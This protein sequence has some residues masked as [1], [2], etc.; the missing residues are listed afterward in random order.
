MIGESPLPSATER[1]VAEASLSAKALS[2]PAGQ[3]FGSLRFWALLYLS[4]ITLAEALTTILPAVSIGLVLYGLVLVGLVLQSA[5][6]PD[7]RSQRMFLTL[8]FAPL[9]RLLS[10]SIPL[11]QI[12]QVY[13]YFSVGA[14]IYISIFIVMRY[15]GFKFSEIGL[16]LGDLRRQIP[17]MFIGIA[18]GISEY[19]IL[20]P[21]PLVPKM[22]FAQ[23]WLPGLILLIFTGFLEEIIFRGLMQVTFIPLLGKWNGLLYVSLIFAVLHYGYGSFSDVV[24][25]FAVAMLFGWIA[26][27]TGSILGVSLAHG[28]TNFTLFLVFPFLIGNLSFSTGAATL[29][30]P[31][32]AAPVTAAAS[33]PQPGEMI[34]V[35]D[36]D[37]GFSISGGIMVIATRG[38]G[39]DL[40]YA[41]NVKDQE[42]LRAGWHPAIP[43][44]GKYA[45][46]VYIP[47][48]YGITHAAAYRIEHLHGASTVI[49]DQFASQG[50]WVR[51]GLYEFAPDQP[52]SLQLT[53][54]TGEPA[55]SAAAAFD[56][57]RWVYLAACDAQ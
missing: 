14:P 43:A 55:G 10:L 57:A 1:L 33:A 19:L 50:R 29:P 22:T 24:F 30:A 4:G 49:L 7:T 3:T 32:D 51:L 54:A 34:V 26:L 6:A 46:E 42:A 20:R 41:Y 23:V 15:S 18:L 52:A 48:D 38:Q 2:R 28:L 21:A 37:S 35:D 36:G 44:C 56:A 13:W 45:L 17:I 25:V 12:P 16:T 47:A 8:A 39:G 11:N 40:Y 9:I 5:S 31:L 27:R 53:N